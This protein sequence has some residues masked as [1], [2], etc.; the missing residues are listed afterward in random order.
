MLMDGGSGLKVF[1]DMHIHVGRAG[2]DKPVKITAARSLTV[3]NILQEAAERK[4]IHMVGIVDAGSPAVQADIAALCRQGELQTLAGGGL[5]YRRK[6]T[7]ILGMEIETTEQKG[8]GHCVV[9]LPSLAMMQGFTTSLQPY[10]TNLQLSTQK[11]RLCLAQVW[12][13]AAQFAGIVMPA[14]IFT[15][16]KSVYG[17]C[18]DSLQEL[19]RPEQLAELKAV[20]L[21]LSSDTYLAELI[22]ELHGVSFLSNSDAHSLPK[23]GREYNLLELPTIDFANFVRALTGENGCRILANY[24][25]DP[26]LGKYHRTF[27][28]ACN[29]VTQAPPPVTVCPECGSPHVVKGVLDRITEITAPAVAVRPPYVH[30][31]PLQFLP[32]LGPKTLAKLLDHFGTEMHVLHFAAEA[33][34]VGVV[35]ATLTRYIMASRLGNI[36]IATGGGGIYGKVIPE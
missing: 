16:Y 5:S 15:P 19:L 4:G 23:I 22:G 26:K 14:H 34:L 10:I 30:Q 28:E 32:G 25:L 2:N 29:T 18:C 20:E 3:A 24:G 33:E 36:S 12:D 1:A 21:G 8:A 9:Y 11:A 35:G 6:L 27:C 7:L 31:V 17:S 13:L